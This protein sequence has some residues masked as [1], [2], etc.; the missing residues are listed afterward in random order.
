MGLVK[1]ADGI[2]QYNQH[3]EG[4]EAQ[5]QPLWVRPGMK[6]RVPVSSRRVETAPCLGAGFPR[7]VTTSIELEADDAKQAAMR[8]HSLMHDTAPTEFVVEDEK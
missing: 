2:I 3:V 1:P 5:E 8:A 6:A 4:I 7:G